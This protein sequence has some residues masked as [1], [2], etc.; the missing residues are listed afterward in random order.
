M[1]QR[2][3]LALLGFIGLLLSGLA[4][5]AIWLSAVEPVATATGIAA[6]RQ[7]DMGPVLK[8]LAGLLSDVLTGILRYI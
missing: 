8:L 1:T 2:L 3:T 6:A 7:G 5:G 4:A